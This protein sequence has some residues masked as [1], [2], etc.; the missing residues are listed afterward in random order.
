MHIS[1]SDLA[2]LSNAQRTT[3]TLITDRDIIMGLHGHFGNVHAAS[4]SINCLHPCGVP[5]PPSQPELEL[6]ACWRRVR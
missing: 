6:I 4:G 2:R 1:E 5:L 3:V